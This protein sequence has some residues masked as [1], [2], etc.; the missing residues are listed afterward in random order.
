L[1]EIASLEEKISA[2]CK[3]NDSYLKYFAGLDRIL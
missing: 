2:Y 1:A 3:F